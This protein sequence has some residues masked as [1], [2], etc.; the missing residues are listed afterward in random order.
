MPPKRGNTRR[1]TQQLAEHVKDGKRNDQLIANMKK[2]TDMSDADVDE[3]A[4]F[5]VAADYFKQP[6]H[7]DVPFK[8]VLR[9]LENQIKEQPADRRTEMYRNVVAGIHGARKNSDWEREAV[10]PN[11]EPKTPYSASKADNPKSN[12]QLIDDLA[13]AMDVDQRTKGMVQAQIVYRDVLGDDKRVVGIMFGGDE[14]GTVHGGRLG[15]DH[16]I[17]DVPNHFFRDQIMDYINQAEVEEKKKESL[18][19]A[20]FSD[21]TTGET[22][23]YAVSISTDMEEARRTVQGEDDR[24]EEIMNHYKPKPKSVGEAKNIIE[25][26]DLLNDVPDDDVDLTKRGNYGNI[27]F[28]FDGPFKSVVKPRSHKLDYEAEISRPKTIDLDCDQIRACIDLFTRDGMWNIDDFRLALG[29]I[30][31]PELTKFLD[32]RGPSEGKTLRVSGLCWE[33]FKTRE[34]LGLD[35]VKS[36]LDDIEMIEK[37][38]KKRPASG[39]DDQPSGKKA[40][41]TEPIDLTDD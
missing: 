16:K 4:Y 34:L 9:D 28:D 15:R 33:F 12:Q 5:M 32:K 7:R 38:G 24:L 25:Q 31:R 10:N 6:D 29:Q 3:L 35:M 8:N 18:R 27:D 20:V 19:I 21:L 37:R 41:T 13:S 14:G 22:A 17:T 36:S 39:D 1:E 11:A 26:H 30:S 40:K 23:A 2:Y